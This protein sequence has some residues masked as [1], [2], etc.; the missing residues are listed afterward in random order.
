MQ[1]PAGIFW[2][3]HYIYIYREANSQQVGFSPWFGGHLLLHLWR[4]HLASRP[5][6]PI[7]GIAGRGTELAN[8]VQ[9]G[10]QRH[11]CHFSSSLLHL[12]PIR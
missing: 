6:V 5:P 8:K 4:V 1:A 11:V 2:N 3:W 9:P 7:A 12:K 10:S